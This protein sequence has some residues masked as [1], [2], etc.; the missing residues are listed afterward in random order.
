MLRSLHIL[1]LSLMG[2]LPTYFPEQ[3]KN[4]QD[5]VKHAG[6]TH[7]PQRKQKKQSE[8]SAH[9]GWDTNR[10]SLSW[11]W[12]NRWDLWSWQNHNLWFFQCVYLGP[13]EKTGSLIIIYFYY[14]YS[15]EDTLWLFW[16]RQGYDVRCTELLPVF[17]PGSRQVTSQ[18][19]GFILALKSSCIILWKI[20]FSSKPTC[21]PDLTPTR[22]KLHYT[23]LKTV[24]D[25]NS[26]D[27]K[28]YRLV[29][30]F[31]FIPHILREIAALTVWVSG[32]K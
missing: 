15:K 1:F 19:F 27:L 8:V 6:R 5:D 13:P 25:L 32:Q 7:K 11:L 12:R 21:L 17:F 4:M 2:R 29:S 14:Y 3:T 23:R 22:L 24:H 20:R 18:S 9:R 28:T 30:Y 10:S 16:K 26:G 31:L